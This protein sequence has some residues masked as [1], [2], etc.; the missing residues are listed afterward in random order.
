MIEEA[1]SALAEM[2]LGPKKPTTKEQLRQASNEVRRAEKEVAREQLKAE[3]DAKSRLCEAKKRAQKGDVEGARSV[4][5]RIAS[6]RALASRLRRVGEQLGASHAAIQR[7]KTTHDVAQAMKKTARAMRLVNNQCDLP[8]IRSLTAAYAKQSM[9]MEQTQEMMDDSVDMAFEDEDENAA[10]EVFAQVMDEIGIETSARLP[11][12]AALRK[13]GAAAAAAERPSA[14]LPLS[15]EAQA[16]AAI[17]DELERRA[18]A[19][20]RP[21]GPGES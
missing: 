11:D 14:Q 3:N 20:G 19:L 15:A 2:I 16:Q 13:P 21:S 9:R 17:D 7:A 1:A 8:T 18:R 10:D 6:D 5:R 4:A 12:V